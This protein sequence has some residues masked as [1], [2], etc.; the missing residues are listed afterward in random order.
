MFY[1]VIKET[2][3]GMVGTKCNVHL[4]EPN[5]KM[6]SEF[7][8]SIKLGWLQKVSSLL[9]RD[10][11]GTVNLGRQDNAYLMKKSMLNIVTLMDLHQSYGPQS[12]LICDAN[13]DLFF[14]FKLQDD[15]RAGGYLNMSWHCHLQV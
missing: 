4:G 8:S 11:L 7:S 15:S 14:I 13:K 10:Q 9:D 6:S 3:R 1:D 5:D 12:F 2:S